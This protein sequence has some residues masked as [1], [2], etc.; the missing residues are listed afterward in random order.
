MPVGYCALRELIDL[1]M[2]QAAETLVETPLT[3]RE[4]HWIRAETDAEQRVIFLPRASKLFCE[5]HCG[6]LSVPIRNSCA[7]P[8]RERT[9]ATSLVP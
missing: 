5:F 7:L 1:V 3:R 6:F 4:F 2:L 8:N 9:T